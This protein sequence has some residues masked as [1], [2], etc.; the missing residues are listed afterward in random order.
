MLRCFAVLLASFAQLAS[1][2]S[3]SWLVQCISWDGQVRIKSIGERC[4]CCGQDLAEQVRL[5]T[6]AHESH[7]CCKHSRH[8]E[9]RPTSASVPDKNSS[10]CTPAISSAPC[11]KDSPIESAT[12]LST[13]AA[14]DALKDLLKSDAAT[15]VWSLAASGGF[16]TAVIS[17]RLGTDPCR[18]EHCAQLA[19]L[20]SVVLR[21]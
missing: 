10:D 19:A 2:M 13:P 1:A 12:G 20:T 18:R 15:V 7:D 5:S 9:H 4:P 8:D 11:C 3:G 16:D 14:S 21:C 17:V 6:A